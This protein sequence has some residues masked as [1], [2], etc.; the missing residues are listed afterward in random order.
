MGILTDWKAGMN[1]AESEE[2]WVIIIYWKFCQ[3]L[4]KWY[5]HFEI[6]GNSCNLIGFQQKWLQAETCN[7]TVFESLCNCILLSQ[8]INLK[9]YRPLHK[10]Q[11]NNENDNDINDSGNNNYSKNFTLAITTTLKRSAVMVSTM[12]VTT[13][14]YCNNHNDK[15]NDMQ[16]HR[17][18]QKLWQ[19]QNKSNNSKLMLKT[20]IW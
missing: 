15:N 5:N 3:F 9:V 2:H 7:S 19:C 6:I 16:L 14:F 4:S 12:A 10:R 20:T 8:S 11:T 1:V 18:W 17:Q 13:K